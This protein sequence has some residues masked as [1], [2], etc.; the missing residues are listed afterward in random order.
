MSV[1][2]QPLGSTQ[3]AAGT[4]AFGQPVQQQPAVAVFGQPQPTTAGTGLF[5]QLQPQQITQQPPSLLSRLG[6]ATTT[7]TSTPG[8]G[9][10]S[11]STQPAAG[12]GSLSP[13]SNFAAKPAATGWGQSTNTQVPTFSLQPPAGQTQQGTNTFGQPLSSFSLSGSTQQQQQPSTFGTL[14][15]QQQPQQ[16]KPAFQWPAAATWGQSTL[17]QSQPQPAQQQPLGVSQLS[18]QPANPLL[19]SRST[20]LVG[21][22]HQPEKTLEQRAT[23]I[24]E[25]WNPQLTKCKFRHVFYNV[26]TAQ[27]MGVDPARP[28]NVTE[29]EWQNALRMN[30]DPQNLYPVVVSGYHALRQRL[31]EQAQMAN[32]QTVKLK[33]LIEKID[34]RKKL[35]SLQSSVRI[36]QS[37]LIETYLHHRIL[38]ISA[39][40]HLL[41]PDLRTKPIS[42]EE[43]AL[44]TALQSLD[45]EMNSGTGS[46]RMRGKVNELWTAL[47]AYKAMKERDIRDGGK[48]S[49]EWVVADEQG[50]ED[51][52]RVL[53]DQYRALEYITKLLAVDDFDVDHIR[54]EG[55]GI[56]S[57]TQS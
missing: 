5:S 27:E 55:Y 10:P 31:F 36:Q 9:Q 47:G 33:Q 2:G 24:A 21:R 41:M 11:T 56:R 48:D 42:P 43:E 38:A 49:R 6:A 51:M 44:A 14:G 35:Y 50:F 15:Q 26:R 16:Q 53:G 52:K 13:F 45:A 20:G 7:S 40:L 19:A 32:A 8:W 34:E 30:P 39:R 57:P 23:E 28:A 18:I 29:E 25:A 4:N 17:G 37:Q 54:A 12:T 22:L 46:G 1:F 3:P